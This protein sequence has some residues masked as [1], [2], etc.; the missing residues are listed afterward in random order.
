MLTKTRTTP[1]PTPTARPFTPG[2][3]QLRG[4]RPLQDPLSAHVL[5]APPIQR[6]NV[7]TQAGYM[8]GDMYG[9]SAALSLNPTASVLILKETNDQLD[10]YGRD[11]SDLYESFYKESIKQTSTK[12]NKTA[13]ADN[14]VGVLSVNNT[15]SFYKDLT[16]NKGSAKDRVN[17]PFESSDKFLTIGIATSMV[18]SAYEH[19]GSGNK[20]TS[21][22][23]LRRAWFSGGDM[24]SD[25]EI[26]QFLDGKGIK[27]GTPYAFLW[28][29]ASGRN[30][31]A[32]PE[33]DSDDDG[34]SGLA[35]A[36][37]SL[38]RTAVIVGD[39]LNS[40]VATVA[41][42]DA[43]DLIKYWESDPFTGKGRQAQLKMFDY[44]AR[45]GYNVV[46]VGMRSGILEG[47]ALLGIKTIYMEEEG[48]KQ[49]AR[50]EKLIGKVPGYDRVKLNSLPTKVGRQEQLAEVEKQIYD[51][52]E[53][54]TPSLDDLYDWFDNDTDVPA[55]LG[56]YKT[57][58]MSAWRVS[59]W[60]TYVNEN[61]V[62]SDK[63]KSL[64]T[65]WLYHAKR[66]GY[67]SGFDDTDLNKVKD[68]L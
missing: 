21:K 38:G 63:L 11:K 12:H 55:L 48:N 43:I 17:A 14:R 57:R 61:K 18:G 31:G 62:W 49:A 26:K 35:N 27:K 39:A 60:T 68:K 51:H 23:K 25:L 5:G 66:V 9:V 56:E 58:A 50:M 53:T 44:M 64:L 16:N 22:A 42:D 24:P 33:L 65:S 1:A 34:L 32:H 59:N 41:G 7:L 19:D 67:G 37:S 2:V 45:Q 30:G 28:S 10:T 40:D 46:N 15:N 52:N 6:R 54:R 47:P 8:S 4:F 36:V 20:S 29:R 13:D 3:M